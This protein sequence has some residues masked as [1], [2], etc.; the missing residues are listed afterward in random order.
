MSTLG[1]TYQQKATHV[2]NRGKIG[3]NANRWLAHK[4]EV[5]EHIIS[6]GEATDKQFAR[7]V[8][9]VLPQLYIDE[10]KMMH[11]FDEHFDRDWASPIDRANALAILVEINR[12]R[13]KGKRI[14][15]FVEN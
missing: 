5:A 10:K 6:A 4:I 13:G 9:Q 8:W 2:L 7:Y 14:R 15:L 11:A 1:V 3:Q 12:S